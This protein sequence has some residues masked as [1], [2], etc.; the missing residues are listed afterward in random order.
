MIGWRAHLG[1]IFPTPVPGRVIREFY[2]VVPDGVDVT[3][4]SLTIRQLSVEDL[5]E[6]MTHLDRAAAQMARYEVDMVYQLGVPPV[7]LRG[8]G[9]DRELIA[10][11]E[12]ASGKPA[13]TDITGVM[14]AFRALSLRRLVMATPFED[15][16]NELIKKFLG[17]AGFE[18][19]GMKGLGIKKNVDIRKLAVPVE[20]TL[21]REVARESRAEFDGIYVPCGGWGTVHNIRRLEADLGKPVVTWF[22]AMIWWTLRQAGVRE[23]LAGFGKLLEIPR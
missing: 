2:E 13:G 16:M 17:A 1:A 20:Y 8:P 4:A 19:V 10:R 7:V 3:T 22:Q 12:K 18:I 11:M 9:Y 5:E 14:E 6:A 21:A 23:R 15:D